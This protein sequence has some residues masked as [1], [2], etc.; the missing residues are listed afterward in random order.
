MLKKTFLL[1]LAATSIF[2]QSP[3]GMF[4][5]AINKQY[6][7]PSLEMQINAAK[8]I[9]PN[10][11]LSRFTDDALMAKFPERRDRIEFDSTTVASFGYMVDTMDVDIYRYHSN[12]AHLGGMYYTVHFKALIIDPE[13]CKHFQTWEFDSLN[14]LQSF[15][16]RIYTADSVLSIAAHERSSGKSIELPKLNKDDVLEVYFRH[17]FPETDIDILPGTGRTRGFNVTSWTSHPS[18][19]LRYTAYWNRSPGF[20]GMQDPN[21]PLRFNFFGINKMKPPKVLRGAHAKNLAK[22]I[23][24]EKVKAKGGSHNSIRFKFNHPPVV[25][26]E[27]YSVNPRDIYPWG[28][29]SYRGG[30]SE[31]FLNEKAIGLFKGFQSSFKRSGVHSKVKDLAKT[32]EGSSDLETVRNVREYVTKNIDHAEETKRKATKA[33]SSVRLAIESGL[34]SNEDLLNTY[35]QLLGV[36][37]IQPSIILLVDSDRGSLEKDG[38]ILRKDY[39]F[40]YALL[41]IKLGKKTYWIDPMNETVPFGEYSPHLENWR[42]YT[43]DPS[44]S[45]K[46]A[47]RFK[48]KAPSQIKS[49][50][51]LTS[52][53]TFKD[54]YALSIARSASF[55]GWMATSARDQISDPDNE[56]EL[57]EVLEVSKDLFGLKAGDVKIE[58]FYDTGANLELS[59]TFQM[60]N[61]AVI[62]KKQML[63]P[64][65]QFYSAFGNPFQ[66]DTRNDKIDLK[67]TRKYEEHIVVNVPAGFKVKNLPEPFT[68]ENDIMLVS[69]SIEDQGSSVK[70]NCVFEIKMTKPKLS[71]Y[72]TLRQ[73]Y[74]LKGR[75]ISD[76]I[77][78]E[79]KP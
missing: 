41:K 18:N 27:S 38:Q 59:T 72:E 55:K 4:G 26:D 46:K 11:P 45:P 75:G 47:K 37:K 33:R 19:Y 42:G 20:L 30:T 53:I 35:I 63:F 52:E 7:E 10:V 12:L 15:R 32:L 77:V 6:K 28:V 40:D 58:N 51:R 8:K 5:K 79:Q 21:D 17:T 44:I 69:S 50:N 68:Y 71:D 76:I 43:W 24:G 36:N 70:I 9:I 62:S 34:G 31:F 14:T 54:Q 65:G 61:P 56:E 3:I 29:I 1:I 49:L 74:M 25:L 39:Y 67:Y 13:L 48:L 2:A 57:L 64:V 60:E 23:T 16:A 66:E 78:F 73:G 22:E